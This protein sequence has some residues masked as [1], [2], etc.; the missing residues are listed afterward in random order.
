MN[1]E[2]LEQETEFNTLMNEANSAY[3]FDTKREYRQYKINQKNLISL[4]D[5]ID[6]FNYSPPLIEQPQPFLADIQQI[7]KKSPLDVFGLKPPQFDGIK[8]HAQTFVT[9]FIRFCN[10]Y[11]TFHDDAD[12]MKAFIKCHKYEDISRNLSKFTINNPSASFEDLIQFFIT[13][14]GT[15]SVA[16]HIQFWNS[17]RLNFKYPNESRKRLETAANALHF[18]KYYCSARLLSVLPYNWK[19][20]IMQSNIIPTPDNDCWEDLWSFINNHLAEESLFREFDTII[21][22][23]FGG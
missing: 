3:N 2:E 10:A 16:E 15:R 14:H 12:L 23:R 21:S 22:S 13:S 17:F 18:S 6:S 11:T 8:E 9:E 4:Q 1:E 20:S 5:F 19:K 7:P